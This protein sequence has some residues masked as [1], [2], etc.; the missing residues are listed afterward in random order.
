MDN[1]GS[2]LTRQ[3]LDYCWDH[4]ILPFTFPAHLT[5]R[6]QPLD[7]IPFQQYKLQHGNTVNM[8]ARMGDN[9]FDKSDFLAGIQSIRQE[10]FKPR[11]IKAGWREA[12]IHPFKSTEKLREIRGRSSSP[13]LN[14]Y[15]GE[16]SGSGV[17]S[18]LS[19]PDQP[20]E[21]N[22]PTTIRSIRR[23]VDESIES[24]P[25]LSPSIQRIFRG[26]IVQAEQGAQAQ[27]ELERY[28]EHHIK[29]AEKK[30]SSQSYLRKHGVMYVRDALREVD[31]KQAEEVRKE[32]KRME[33]AGREYMNQLFS[34]HDCEPESSPELPEMPRNQFMAQE[35]RIIDDAVSISS[36]GGLLNVNRE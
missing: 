22:T 32:W 6:L 28:Q 3:F 14:I 24:H 10:T 34:R 16:S 26:A 15:D 29:R 19:T 17:S 31:Q 8:A 12:G 23:Q 1:H 2:H 35:V 30:S 11:I 4:K 27:Y 18:R 21:P 36:G 7:L 25:E 5:H 20:I 9:A 13:I 33:K